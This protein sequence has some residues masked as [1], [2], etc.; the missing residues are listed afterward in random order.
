MAPRNRKRSKTLTGEDEGEG[1]RRAEDRKMV[2]G[3]ETMSRWA[4]RAEN[5]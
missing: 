4:A 2:G 1:R 3:A 5:E